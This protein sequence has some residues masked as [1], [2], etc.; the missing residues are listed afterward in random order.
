MKKTIKTLVAVAALTLSAKAQTNW[1]VDAS[2]SKM[3]FAVTHMMV[4]ET[5]GK[6]KIYEG[7]VSSKSDM[8]FTDATI[9]FKVD[10]NSINTD[11]DQ[12]DGHLKGADF[13]DVAKYPDI[14]F[15]ATSMKPNAKVKNSYILKGDLTMHGVT[16]QVTLT[17]IGASKI[18]KDP[19]G[20]MRYAFKVTGK[21]NRTEFGLKY[22]AA[23][24]AG[25]V[26]LSEEVRI[27]CTIELTKAK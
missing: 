10:V 2:H 11:N 14:T 13:F 5:E 12:R 27:D 7:K 4:S 22:N 24:E 21:L 20:M 6:F 3:G 26:A 16:K 9:D 18:V 15:K 23:L 19:Y 1:N 25:G 8:D 17:A